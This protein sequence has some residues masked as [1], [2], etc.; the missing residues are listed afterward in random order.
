MRLVGLY[1]HIPFCNNKCPYCDFYSKK[2]SNEELDKFTDELCN[3]LTYWKSKFDVCA[4][5]LY[6]GGGTPSVLGTKRIIQIIN[7]AR[8]LFLLDNAEITIEVNP[9]SCNL[10]DFK[11]LNNACVNRVSIG[12]QSANN[13]E[14]QILGRKHSPL[15]AKNVVQQI[16][17]G[18]I[19]N[20]SLDLMIGIPEQTIDSLEKSINFVL[21]CDVNHISAY[22]L[23]IEENT[24]FSK[25]I[26]KL[27]LPDED[28]QIELYNYMCNKLKSNGYSHYEISN[29]CKNNLYSKHNMK[30]WNCDEYIGIGPSAHS[31][32]QE[33]RFYYPRKMTDFYENITI[34]DGIGGNEE[35]YIMLRLRLKNGI[36]F[37]EYENRFKKNIGSNIIKNAKRLQNYGLVKVTDNNI[38]I[39][40][41]GYM[42]SNSIIAS[43]L[44]D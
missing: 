27:N 9:S 33:K 30:Y 41:N 22:I 4:D 32:I 5:T 18:G 44:Y 11:L 42:L 38:F 26:E 29:F 24:V 19:Q 36:V 34:N 21:D 35:E 12:L 1:F 10:L 8:E 39:T 15:D 6:F 16:K 14:L 13:N 37:K 20:I 43:L 31:Y 17:A 2:F 23:K 25:I 40:E 7:K 28:K 3:K